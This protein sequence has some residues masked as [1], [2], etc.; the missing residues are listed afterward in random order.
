MEFQFQGA[1]F[2]APICEKSAPKELNP[3]FSASQTGSN[4]QIV[5][6]AFQSQSTQNNLQSFV[7]PHIHKFEHVQTS[8]AQNHNLQNLNRERRIEN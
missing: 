4:S 1:A 7:K 5:H 8:K 6:H 3:H 2:R